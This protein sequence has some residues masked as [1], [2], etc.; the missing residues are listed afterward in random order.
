[1]NIDNSELLKELRIFE[2][3]QIKL[4]TF[5]FILTMIKIL[6]CFSNTQNGETFIIRKN[7]RNCLWLLK[8]IWEFSED[9]IKSEDKSPWKAETENVKYVFEEKIIKI[10]I[11]WNSWNMAFQPIEFPFQYFKILLEYSKTEI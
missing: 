5:S 11:K 8:D 9:N 7:N 10:I 6:K 3:E 2:Q 4:K 1:M